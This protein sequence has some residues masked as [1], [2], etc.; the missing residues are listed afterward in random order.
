[1]ASEALG[2]PRSRGMITGLLLLALGVWGGL[3]PFIGPYFGYAYTPDAAWTFTMGRL[4]L[5]ILPAAA[6]VLGALL[7]IASG[8]RATA[9][10]GGWLAAAGG[11]WFV[12]GPLFSPFWGAADIGQP[13]GGLGH[14][15]LVQIGF[16]YGLG[17]VIT[18]L[19]GMALGRMAVRGVRDTRTVEARRAKREGREAEPYPRER[20]PAQ[21]QEP[22]RGPGSSRED[23]TRR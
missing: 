4:W 9:S 12:I 5:Q 14:Q 20:E 16:F 3:I 11:A 6:V 18:F 1:M 21:D 23:R 7:L 19:S 2:V 8:N 17:A 10:A 13:V 22:A 15:S